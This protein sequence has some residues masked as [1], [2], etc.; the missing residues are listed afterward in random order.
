MTT[1]PT[2]AELLQLEAHPEGGWFRETWTAPVQFQPDGYDGLRTTGSAIYFVLGPGDSSRWHV[3]R[4]D[5]LWLWHRGGSL[6]L[7]LGGDGPRPAE[8]FT[9]ITVGPDVESGHCPQAVVPAGVWQAAVP[10]ADEAVLVS[11][12]VSP[13]FTFADFRMLDE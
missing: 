7:Q 5:E 3:V 9:E 13:G 4:S 1:K 8:P 11:C 12:I 6:T 2:L 10:A